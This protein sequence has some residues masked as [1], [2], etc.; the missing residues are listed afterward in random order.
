MKVS[1]VPL[2]LNLNLFISVQNGLT[3]HYSTFSKIKQKR[4]TLTVETVVEVIII[5]STMFEENLYIIII[6]I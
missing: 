6:I 4:E 1:V 2:K 5:I 3:W